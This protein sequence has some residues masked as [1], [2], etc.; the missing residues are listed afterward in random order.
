[1]TSRPLFIIQCP[2]FL[3]NLSNLWAAVFLSSSVALL[4]FL[5]VQFLVWNKTHFL[6]IFLPFYS[7]HFFLSNL[8]SYHSHF[9]DEAIG[10]QTYQVIMQCHIASK[11]KSWN[12]NIKFDFRVSFFYHSMLYAYMTVFC[13]LIL[14]L[15]IH[16]LLNP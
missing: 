9:I 10:S 6:Y 8:T 2:L 13:V 7:Q 16:F 11:C 14:A 15:R 5:K 1:M 4:T 12:A 3:S